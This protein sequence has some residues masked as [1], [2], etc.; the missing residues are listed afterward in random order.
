M[1][2]NPHQGPPGP[3][4]RGGRVPDLRAARQRPD[5]YQQGPNQHVSRASGPGQLGPP[6]PGPGPYQQ[7]PQISGASRRPDPVEQPT[8]P[9][10]RPVQRYGQAP[11]SVVRNEHGSDPYQYEPASARYREYAQAH[12]YVPRSEEY[13]RRP[14]PQPEESPI[15]YQRERDRRADR[16]T[17]IANV[18]RLAT[19]LIA[20]CFVLHIVFVLF[21][22]NQSSG[23]VSF[24]ALMAKVFLLGFGKVFTPSNA[25][26]GVVLND[27]LAAIIYAVTGKLV[28]RTLRRR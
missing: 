19:A 21:G 5:G 4:P 27:G 20:L 12:E 8:T 11:P 14:Y 10:N 17:I 6:V 25:T 3:P 2:D 28:A 18:I 1:T 9:Y 24:S 13:Q 15:A 23:I 26:I 22:A 16:V 7:P